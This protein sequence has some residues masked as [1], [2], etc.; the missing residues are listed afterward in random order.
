MVG[1]KP[2]NPTTIRIDKFLSNLK[3][4]GVDLADISKDNAIYE[5]LLK[6]LL[7]T[8]YSP[9]ESV[10]IFAKDGDSKKEI[11]ARINEYNNTREDEKDKIVIFDAV[12]FVTDSIATMIDVVSIVLIVFTSISLVVSGFLIGI[13]TYVSVIERTKEIGILR[14]IGARKKDIS[15]LFNAETFIIGL[16]AGVIGVGTTY[17]LSIPINVILNN[18]FPEQNIGQIA[19]LVPLAA[20]ALIVFNILLTVTAG[21]IPSKMAAN[22]DPVV[23]LRTE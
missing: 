22:K 2:V 12:E 10:A 9:V 3:I 15:R 4:Y 6:E 7:N 11:K 17:I 8:A 23:A 1:C 16:L 20:L 14:A 13:I 19:F 21:L 18:L 5:T